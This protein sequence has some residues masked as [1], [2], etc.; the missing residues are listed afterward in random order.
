MALV[1][2]TVEDSPNGKVKVVADPSFETM[3]KMEISG[4]GLSSAHG[5]ALVAIN[6]IRKMSK[7]QSND[8]IV[9]LPKIGR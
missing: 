9:S 7:E 6:A 2:I 4:H 8:L 3:A 1:T 5:Y